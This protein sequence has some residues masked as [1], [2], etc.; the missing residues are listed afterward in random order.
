MDAEI[1]NPKSNNLLFWVNET[2]IDA[3]LYSAKTILEHYQGDRYFRE[4]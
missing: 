4:R 3:Y 2:S 1:S